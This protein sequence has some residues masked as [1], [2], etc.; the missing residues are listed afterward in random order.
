MQG[1]RNYFVDIRENER[2]KFVKVKLE[3]RSNPIIYVAFPLDNFQEFTTKFS[4]LYTRHYNPQDN[5][6]SPS[7]LPLLLCVCVCV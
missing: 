5:D 2:G 4:G 3:V 1:K 7:M 6:T